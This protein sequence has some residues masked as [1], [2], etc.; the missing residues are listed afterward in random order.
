MA[1]LT[2]NH[3][4]AM[5]NFPEFFTLLRN[6]FEKKEIDIEPD[7]DNFSG[8]LAARYISFV[9]PSLCEL[10]N[11]TLNKSRPRKMELK[12]QEAYKLLDM[13]IPKMEMG[14]IDYVKKNISTVLRNNNISDE[15]ISRLSEFYQISVR[16]IKHYLDR[17]L[18]TTQMG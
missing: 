12:P 14:F 17:E 9:H 11:S 10:M 13:M 16:E 1:T 8:F 3:F 5:L 6:L 2:S 18:T 4:N 15:E 7:E